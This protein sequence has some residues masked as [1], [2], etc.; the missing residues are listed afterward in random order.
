MIR[1][2]FAVKGF[3]APLGDE[4]TSTSPPRNRLADAIVGTDNRRK[5]SREALAND[6]MVMDLID[7]KK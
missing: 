3:T 2:S 7:K 4:T 1:C 6:D 5:E